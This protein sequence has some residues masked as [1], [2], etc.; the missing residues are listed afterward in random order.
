MRVKRAVDICVAA[1]LLVFV[2]PLMVSIA[3]LVKLDSPGPVLFKQRRLGPDDRPY[4]LYKF[5]SMHC[6]ASVDPAL[7][8]ERRNDREA[9]PVGR[10]LRRTSLDELPQLINVL[11][12]D[13][14]LVAAGHARE[15]SSTRMISL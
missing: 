9:T 3:I 11:K 1:G 2:L 14:S 4:D 15:P 10:F 12:G 13:M 6:P 8:R 7:P 5:R